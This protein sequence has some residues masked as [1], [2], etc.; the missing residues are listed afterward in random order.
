MTLRTITADDLDT[1]DWVAAEEGRWR[2]VADLTCDRCGAYQAADSDPV[3]DKPR[4]TELAMRLFNSAGWKVDDAMGA[5]LCP[6]CAVR[7]SD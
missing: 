5:T 1:L 4:A 6:D 2:I 3:R 7:P